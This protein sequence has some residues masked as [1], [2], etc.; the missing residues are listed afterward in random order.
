M[1]DFDVLQ[2]SDVDADAERP[3]ETPS[4]TAIALDTPVGEVPRGPAVTLAPEATVAAAIETMRRR[5]R[6]SAVVVRQHRPVGVVTDRD[7]LGRAF[8]TI[9][10]LGQ[11]PLSSVM[12]P[13]PTPLR[14][15]D[16]VGTALR[17]M[18]ALGRWHLP[19][20]CSRG[21]VLGTIDFTD[22]ALWLRDRMIALSV[23]AAFGP[24]PQG[25]S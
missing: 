24:S 21:L 17:R 5:A 3:P 4:L 8:P 25:P 1:F 22:L 15:S 13:C 16:T 18:C 10:E 7:I 23:D 19:L 6:G 9:E 11:M 20:V 14:E 2:I 12:A